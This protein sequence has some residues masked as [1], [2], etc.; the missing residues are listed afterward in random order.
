MGKVKK[1]KRDTAEA[2]TERAFGRPLCWCENLFS[3]ESIGL[4]SPLVESAHAQTLH[5]DLQAQEQAVNRLQPALCR[6]DESSSEQVHKCA[7]CFGL[8]LPPAIVSL[9]DLASPLLTMMGILMR[10]TLEYLSSCVK[11]LSPSSVKVL[12]SCLHVAL[13]QSWVFYAH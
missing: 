2:K 6:V 9:T 3:R 5:A 1:T 11:V 7:A 13:V 4:R 12:P 10:N 8:L